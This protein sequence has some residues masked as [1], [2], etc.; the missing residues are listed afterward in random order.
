MPTFQSAVM[1]QR[2]GISQAM[3]E[4][5]ERLVNKE[6]NFKKSI[7]LM[8]HS[9]QPVLVLHPGGLVRTEGSDNHEVQEPGD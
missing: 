9:S 3:R 2:K 8:K 6:N 5:A 1:Q 4:R 7:R